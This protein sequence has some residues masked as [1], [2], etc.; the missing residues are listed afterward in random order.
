[1]NSLIFTTSLCASAVTAFSPAASRTA[2]PRHA[3]GAGTALAQYGAMMGG[4]G[5]INVA[6]EMAQRDVYAMDEWATQYGVQKAEGIELYTEDGSDFTLVSQAQI[7]AGTTLIYVPNEVCLSATAAVNEF[8][9]SLQQ[10]EQVLVQMD[11]GTQKR[12]PLFRLMVKIL[13][14]YDKGQDRYVDR[15]ADG[16][17]LVYNQASLN[18]TLC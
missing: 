14:E 2:A 12:L 4:N 6:D 5:L 3:R 9:G 7:P 17:C 8:G 1:M 15:R 16:V 10:A 18:C 13:A 11:Q